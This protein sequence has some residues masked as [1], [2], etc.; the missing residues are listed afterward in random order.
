MATMSISSIEVI[1]AHTKAPFWFQLYVMKDEDFVDKL[2]IANTHDFILCFSN[3]GQVYWLK[4][5][6]VPV[7]SS[8]SR[9][10]PINNLVP[11]QDGEKIT[12]V[13]P[14][15]TFDDDH[16]VFMAT[17]EGTVKNHVSNILSKLGVRDRTRA[18]LKA[19][20]LKLV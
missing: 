3:R 13:L 1:A 10:K 14:V 18:V 15:K 4:V 9:G 5:Y 6:E 2:F 7:G 20:E 16:Y 19:F 17:A 11:L 12:A 8:A